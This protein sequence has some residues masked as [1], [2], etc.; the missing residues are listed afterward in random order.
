MNLVFATES[1]QLF[2]IIR[3]VLI[4]SYVIYVVAKM[5]THIALLYIFIG[6]FGMFVA[7][8]LK[9]I[10]QELVTPGIKR[11]F[12]T[13]VDFMLFIM[14]LFVSSALSRAGSSMLTFGSGSNLGNI[15][16]VFVFFILGLGIHLILPPRL[17]IPKLEDIDKLK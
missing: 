8:Y 13:Y 2:P 9:G 16:V 5:D 6:T 14:V 3:G 12:T 10:G 15:S 17:S 4:G 1:S 7:L 11:A